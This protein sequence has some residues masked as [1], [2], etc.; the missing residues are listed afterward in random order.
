MMRSKGIDHHPVRWRAVMLLA[1]AAGL[2]TACDKAADSQPELAAAAATEP[3]AAAVDLE[4]LHADAPAIDWFK[5][6]VDAAFTAA[7]AADKPVFLYWGAQWCPPCKQLKSSVFSRPDFIAKSRS[8]VAVYLDGDLPKAQKWG[9]EF[10]VTGYP[11][12]VIFKPDRTEIMRLSGGM[13]LSLYGAVLDNV[14]GD[15]RPV[16]DV[17]AAAAAQK[18]PL[19]A[20]DCRRF[21]YHAFGLEDGEIFSNELLADGF[22]SA[23]LRC[24]PQLT[25]ERGRF[26]ILAAG[27]VAAMEADAVS[28]GEPPSTRLKVLIAKVA[29]LLKDKDLAL[30]N[31]DALR[32]LGPEFFVAARAGTPQLL[33]NLRDRWMATADAAALDERFA[34][35]DQLAAQLLKINAA[36]AFAR[37]GRVPTDIAGGALKA[38]SEMLA[39]SHESYVRASVVNS[40]VNIYL[41][42]N[43]LTR[44]RDL[45]AAEARTSSN[46]HY[47]L[48]DLA[49][50]EEKLGNSDSALEHYAAAYAQAKGPASRFQWGF[51][52][53]SALV[54]LRPDDAAAIERVGTSVLAELTGPDSVHRRTRGRL[55]RLDAQLRQWNDAAPRAAVIAKLRR[56]FKSI[57]GAACPDFLTTN[58]A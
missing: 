46:P 12:V 4:A 45:L 15:V 1:C 44:A 53:L 16:R 58:A 51:N 49:D 20:D 10:R 23:A 38:A 41:A 14:L 17:L 34:P 26:Q 48:G 24:P 40:A 54:R 31:S 8:F 18:E 56:Q 39:A 13:D 43:E 9:D 52:Y 30:T 28:R 36:R 50:V 21:A 29:D 35:A 57:C 6:D 55:D 19:S 5:G 27:R 25:R 42:L 22:E 2:L 3:V 11:T 47:Y 7:Q 33:G 32:Q 37:D